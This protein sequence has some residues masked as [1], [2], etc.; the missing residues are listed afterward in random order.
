MRDLLR[1]LTAIRLVV[2]DRI[3]PRPVQDRIASTA[4]S[5]R[6]EARKLKSD[7]TAA[8]EAAKWTVELKIIEK[9]V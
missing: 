4:S 7:A 2:L 8:L 6:S 3:P 5:I 9:I 1:E